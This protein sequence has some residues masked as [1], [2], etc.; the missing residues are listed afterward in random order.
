MIFARQG[1][2]AQPG[3][4]GYGGRGLLRISGGVPYHQL[5]RCSG[6]SAGVVDLTNGQLEASEQVPAGLDPARPGER[7][8]SADLD[9]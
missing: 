3:Q 1:G 4:F 7:N 2:H 8:E 5:E 6:D 9:C